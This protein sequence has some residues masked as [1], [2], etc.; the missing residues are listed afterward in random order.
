VAQFLRTK[1]IKQASA[2]L[3]LLFLGIPQASL[4]KISHLYKSD[5]KLNLLSQL[6]KDFI[7][8][9]IELYC[10]KLMHAYFP[11]IRTINDVFPS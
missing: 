10:R 2:F 6:D 8:K 5:R 1:R 11:E 4:D 7:E 9:N 3:N